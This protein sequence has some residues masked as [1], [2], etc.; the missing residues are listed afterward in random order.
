MTQLTLQ[1]DDELVLRAKAYSARTGKSL[2]DLVA[3]YFASLANESAGP[4][5]ELPAVTIARESPTADIPDSLPER[6]YRLASQYPGEYVVLVGERVVHHS[7]DREQA[8]RAYS[9]AFITH[10]SSAPVMV[11]PTKSRQGRPKPIVRGR[12]LNRRRRA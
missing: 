7:T 2:V 5:A 11:D 8:G 6:Q 12:A 3:D 10:P 4:T 1:L 9:R